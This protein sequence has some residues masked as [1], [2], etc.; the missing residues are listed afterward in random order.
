MRDPRTLALPPW[1]LYATVSVSKLQ[2][3]PPPSLSPLF[4]RSHAPPV[5]VLGLVP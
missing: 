4:S 1:A 3:C 2:P 5:R